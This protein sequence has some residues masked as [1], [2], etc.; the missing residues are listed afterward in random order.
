MVARFLG[1]DRFAANQSD[2]CDRAP[3]ACHQCLPDSLPDPSPVLGVN[4]GT[5]DSTGF[6]LECPLR[7][8][9]RLVATWSDGL[10]CLGSAADDVGNLGDLD[11]KTS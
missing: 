7:S 6:D 11:R 9:A 8:H 10:G 2:A 5:G 3:V 4:S 1:F